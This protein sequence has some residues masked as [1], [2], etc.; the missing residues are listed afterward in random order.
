MQTARIS[1]NPNTQ[2][3]LNK[4]FHKGLN[5]VFVCCFFKNPAIKKVLELLPTILFCGGRGHYL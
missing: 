4:L 5:S 1:S 3:N 2:L